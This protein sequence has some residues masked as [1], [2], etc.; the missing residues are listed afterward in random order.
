MI[1]P[2]FITTEDREEVF[3]DCRDVVKKKFIFTTEISTKE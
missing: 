3:F 2:N 1:L